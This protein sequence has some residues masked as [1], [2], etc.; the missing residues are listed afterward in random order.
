VAWQPPPPGAA[1][2][3]AGPGGDRLPAWAASAAAAA[4]SEAAATEAAPAG[5]GEGA[6]VLIAM[7]A[8]DAAEWQETAS[9]AEVLD[10]VLGALRSV[11]GAAA[12]PRPTAHIITR[13]RSDPHARMSYSYLPPGSHGSAYDLLAAPVDGQLLF[14][15]EATN[16]HHPTTAA[17]AFDSGLR[18]AVRLARAHGRARDA[19]V[20]RLLGRRAARLQAAA[21]QQPRAA[22][23]AR[24]A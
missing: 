16:R 17:G 8:G 7:M 3:A 1:A 15:G 22:A 12:V 9:D 20:M 11:F 13:W 18:E 21:A 4:L 24:K 6:P 2:A 14:A 5:G 19:D 10:A 23:S